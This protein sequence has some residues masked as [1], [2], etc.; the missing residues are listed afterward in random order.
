M[1]KIAI[2]DDEMEFAEQ[3]M[4]ITRQYFESRGIVYEAMVYQMPRELIWDLEEG[5][6]FD[7]YLIDVEMPTINGLELAHTIRQKYDEPFI[8]F[9]TSH[10]EYSIKGYEYNAWRYIVKDQIR[11]TLPLAFESIQTR[12][13][14]K[15][16]KLY[17]IEMHSK[18]SKMSYDDIYYIHKDGKYTNFYTN[19]GM[20][21]ERKPISKVYEGLN[22]RAFQFADRAYVVNLRHLMTL[23]DHLVIMRDGTEIPVSIPQFQK[24]KKA[25]S[26][27]W[28]ESK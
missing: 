11:E 24:L 19:Q 28:R 9:I 7:I 18:V 23:G 27:Y 1:L 21:R 5:H 10:V 4:E 25:V 12:I 15:P 8:I 22:D 14:E 6:Y 13:A 26:A 3:V 16:Q 17:V 20:F 2:V